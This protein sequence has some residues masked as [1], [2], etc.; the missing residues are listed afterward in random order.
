ML[1][2]VSARQPHRPHL[3]RPCPR[4]QGA[5][6]PKAPLPDT[7]QDRVLTDPVVDAR[8][9]GGDFGHRGTG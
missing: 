9:R 3:C 7:A 4:D 2:L 8:F 1:L 6:P 5:Q